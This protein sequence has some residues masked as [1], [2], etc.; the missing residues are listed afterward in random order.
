MTNEH[1]EEWLT[2]VDQCRAYN[3]AA[4]S[5]GAIELNTPLR[6]E[7]ILSLHEW[8]QRELARIEKM[9]AITH[10]LNLDS[11]VADL[12]QKQP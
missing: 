5:V 10:F 6:R 4:V 11:I 9:K 8:I 3:P 2:I 12:A 1:W 7:T